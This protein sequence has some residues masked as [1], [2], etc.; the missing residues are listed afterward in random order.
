MGNVEKGTAS[1]EGNG[2][3][4]TL[5]QQVRFIRRKPQGDQSCGHTYPQDYPNEDQQIVRSDV[6]EN[7]AVGAEF[8]EVPDEGLFSVAGAGCFLPSRKIWSKP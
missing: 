6:I 1:G 3:F 5:K 8:G 2:L 4:P 7:Y